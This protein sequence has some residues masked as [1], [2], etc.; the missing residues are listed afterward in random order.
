MPIR[1]K[2]VFLQIENSDAMRRTDIIGE[3]TRLALFSRNAMHYSV[4]GEGLLTFK[5]KA[6]RFFNVSYSQE[7]ED[8]DGHFTVNI[9]TKMTRN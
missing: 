6:T 1:K 9:I 2:V 4:F 5:M 7:G 3:K 8:E